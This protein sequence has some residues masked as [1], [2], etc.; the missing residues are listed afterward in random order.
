[1]L[2][3]IVLALLAGFITDQLVFPDYQYHA[4][5]E[6]GELVV[7]QCCVPLIFGDT[8]GGPS[9]FTLPIWHWPFGAIL[10]SVIL[11]GTV[12]KMRF[13]FENPCKACN[14]KSYGANGT[15]GAKCHVRRKYEFFRRN[16]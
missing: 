12:K 6:Q 15:C 5:R 7:Q 11:Y 1:M 2:S 14:W 3:L 10:A 9:S 13:F 8:V 4:Y 16:H